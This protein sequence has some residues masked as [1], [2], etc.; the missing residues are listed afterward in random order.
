VIDGSADAC[1]AGVVPERLIGLHQLARRIAIGMTISYRSILARG[2]RT[3][4]FFPDVVAD[5][6]GEFFSWASLVRAD[7]LTGD[8]RLG[9]G[10]LDIGLA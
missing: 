9:R 5:V 8:Q 3:A 6:F 1:A 4:A 2:P 7:R 10:V